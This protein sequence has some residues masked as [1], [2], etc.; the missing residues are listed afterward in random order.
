MASIRKNP[1]R[2]A[3]AKLML[4]SMW[5][6]FG[7]RLDKTHVE[8]F[9]DPRDLHAFL[10]SGRH[11]VSYVSPIT[12]ERIEIYYKDHE[13]TIDVNVNLNIFVACFTTC[14]ARLKLYEELERYSSR[15]LLRHRLDHLHP[16]YRRR[17]IPTSLRQV[18]G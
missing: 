4:N 11:K 13:P 8:E 9:T 15:C 12:D 6:K 14:W 10:A 2:R 16:S 1:G 5:G 18:P 7:Q 3:E 17:A